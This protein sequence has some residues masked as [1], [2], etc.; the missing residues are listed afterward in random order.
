MGI[1]QALKNFQTVIHT[2]FSTAFAKC[3]D[4]IDHSEGEIRPMESVA[5]DFPKDT[6]E[7]AIRKFFRIA[8]ATKGSA[9]K[10]LSSLLAKIAADLS[11][12]TTMI[13]LD[14]YFRFKRS[15]RRSTASVVTPAKAEKVAAEKPSVKFK[16]SL[17]EEPKVLPSK[18]RSGHLGFQLDRRSSGH[19]V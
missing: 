1:I 2:V 15:R 3:L 17:A 12:A 13:A 19:L 6:V 11:I 9:L 18:P 4:F 16:L 14:G 10:D 8:R 5:T 7:L